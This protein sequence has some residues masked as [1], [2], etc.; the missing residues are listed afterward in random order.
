M[1]AVWA[2][3]ATREV[4]FVVSVVA[5]YFFYLY[6]GIK[7]EQLYAAICRFTLFSTAVPATRCC[8]HAVWCSSLLR[9]VLHCCYAAYCGRV[10][11]ST[12]KGVILR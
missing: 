8:N 11:L 12:I 3:S 2:L 7:Q 1:E 10:T 6:Y 4:R 9:A 5:V